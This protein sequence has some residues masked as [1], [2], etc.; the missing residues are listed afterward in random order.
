MI[1]AVVR[2]LALTIA[3]WIAAAIVPGI[4]YTSPKGLL[5]AALV[6]SILNSFV[7]P[8]LQVISIP[9]IIMSFGLFLLVINAILLGLTAWLVPEFHVASIGSALGGSLVISIVSMFLGYTGR[10]QRIVV[11]RQQSPPPPGPDAPPGKGRIID[12]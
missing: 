11:D 12:V 6:L 3:V 10:R 2:W 1:Q 5:I 7:K 9:F 4:T 8:I